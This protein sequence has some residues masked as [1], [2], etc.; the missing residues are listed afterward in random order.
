MPFFNTGPDHSFE[1]RI[2]LA[3]L[4]LLW[5]AIWRNSL[6]LM[7]FCGLVAIAMLLGLFHMLSRPLHVGAMVLTAIGFLWTLRP[8]LRIAMPGREAALRRLETRSGLEHRPATSYE[9]TLEAAPADTT[10]LAL[11][12]MHK[13]RLR[14]RIAGLKP[15]WPSPGLPA[16]DPNGLRVIVLLGLVVALTWAGPDATDRV[17]DAFKPQASAA[18]GA[19]TWVDAWI[20]PPGY[21][22]RAPVFL[23]GAN[24]T[25]AA[26]DP[27]RAVDV[28]VNSEL[29]VRLTGAED[30][31]ARIV[32][33]DAGTQTG[34]SGT[35]DEPGESHAFT[36]DGKNIKSLRLKLLE[37][38]RAVI[39]DGGK[40]LAGWRFSVIPD[41]VPSIRL[42]RDVALTGDQAVRFG[43]SINDDYGVISAAAA[44]KLAPPVTGEDETASF[45][46]PVAPPDF[47]LVLPK[48]RVKSAA[49]K[50][51]RDLTAHPWA[52]LDVEL[53]LTATDEAD[54]TGASEPVVFTLPERNFRQPLARAFIEQRKHL[55]LD[56]DA[57]PKVARAL[58]GLM[59]VSDRLKVESSVYLGMSMI[60]HRLRRMDDMDSRMHAVDLL[61]E[62]ALRVED[63]NLSLAERELR[64]A[65]EALRR[66]IAE[67]APPEEIQRLMNELRQALDKFM[68]AMAEQMRRNAQNGK[69]QPQQ[70]LPPNAQMINPQDLA[71]MMDM[72][73]QLAKNGA[74][75]A[76]QELLSQLNDILE[77]LQTA[78]PMPGQQGQQSQMS[79]MLEELGELM[80]KQQGL[81]D[82]TFQSGPDR[83]GQSSRQGESG[84]NL[85]GN[86][87]SGLAQRQDGIRDLLGQLMQQFGPG[88]RNAPNALD[89]AG[90]AMEDAAGALRRNDNPEAVQR[91][92]EAI[93][94]MRQGAN[95]MAREM[96]QGMG[97]A[98]NPGQMGQQRGRGEV[99][100]LGRSTRTRGPDFGNSTKVPSEI[101]VQRAREIM[102]EL[103][104]RLGER[105]RPDIELKY[106]ERL[107]DRF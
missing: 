86:Q 60:H 36:D 97:Q 62:L 64:A 47:A 15:G 49:Q 16:I 30:P 66:A 89:R 17:R 94:Q 90:R 51:F 32:G 83:P 42:D 74:M 55:V 41:R 20:A 9:D 25:V 102:R 92:A 45:A 79:K 46:L 54:Q 100:P 23:S 82:E 77:N 56:K 22:G 70:Q 69:Q 52:G 105:F 28:P 84:Q 48:A 4:V 53:T 67:N 44:F 10:G 33:A 29:I 31:A 26:Q 75:D 21:T 68:Q 65:Q 24:V 106:I 35:D 91:Q 81:M 2:L 18:T 8:L 38:G 1:R 87:N 98:E 107:L 58:S 104:K 80:G 14:E 57:A 101:E 3:R 11:W 96:L 95:Q 7:V 71:K 19:R 13:A 6:P 78:Q 43:Y 5:E 99:D 93:D 63:G 40:E 59:L 76:A 27:D 37:S 73:E 50:V 61:W 39:E 103:Q 34:E 88:N 85:Q 72:I 12:R